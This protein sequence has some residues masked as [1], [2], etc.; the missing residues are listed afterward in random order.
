MNLNP[1][2]PTPSN[3]NVTAS[4][5]ERVPITMAIAQ[6]ACLPCGDSNCTPQNFGV[7]RT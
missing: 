4:E 3:F 7:K 2:C 1:Y 5:V 6:Y